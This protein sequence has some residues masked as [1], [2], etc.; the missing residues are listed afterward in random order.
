MKKLLSLVLCLVLV[1]SMAA[2]GGN[3]TTAEPTKAP[4]ENKQETTT[5]G[6]TKQEAAFHTKEEKT[7][8]PWVKAPTR[9]LTEPRLWSQ[10]RFPTHWLYS[11][12][13]R[14]LWASASSAV[15]WG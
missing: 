6:D 1:L 14:P 9:L 2:C 8:T 7:Q 15:K 5:P 13:T 3:E 4:V 12:P 11:A 10:I